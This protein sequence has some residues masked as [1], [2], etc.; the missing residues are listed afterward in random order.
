MLNMAIKYLEKTDA[1]ARHNLQNFKWKHN[2]NFK[3]KRGE[4]YFYLEIPLIQV[5]TRH[6]EVFEELWKNFPIR[7]TTSECFI[8]KILKR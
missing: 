5:A 3:S 8:Y 1:R 6:M 7:L 4:Q 2:I